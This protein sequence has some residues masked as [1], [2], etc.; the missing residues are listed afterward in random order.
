M[1][2]YPYEILK[3]RLAIDVPELREIDWYLQQ[4]STTDKNTWLYAAPLLFI[5]FQP[6]AT[7]SLGGRIQ[8]AEVDIL[9]HLLTE[10]VMDSGKRMKK[11]HPLD[12]MRIFDKVYKSL[13]GFSSKLSYLPEFVGLLNTSQDRTVMNSLSRSAIAPPHTIRKAMM[14]S[15]QT[16][17]CVIYDHAACKQYTVPAPLPGLDIAVTLSFDIDEN[18][19]PGVFD[20]PFGEEFD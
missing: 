12:H 6:L 13:L 15:V 17:R 11:D 8:S 3:L 5:E 4:D 10:N 14:K 18:T 7:D 9:I 20:I 19:G 16:F 1:L 2:T